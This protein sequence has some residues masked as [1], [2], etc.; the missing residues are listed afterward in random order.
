VLSATLG[1]LGAMF[2]W[3]AFGPGPRHFVS[4]SNVRL[5]GTVSEQFGR[6]RFGIVAVCLALAL[7]TQLVRG[8]RMLR[9]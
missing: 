2:A 8:V 6:V 1:C 3:V 7:T 9:C 5:L 4:R